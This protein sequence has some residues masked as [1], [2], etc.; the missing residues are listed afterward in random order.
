MGLTMIIPLLSASTWYNKTADMSLSTEIF[1]NAALNNPNKVEGYEI[2][3]TF[4]NLTQSVSNPSVFYSVNFSLA[5][6]EM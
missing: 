5:K 4:L 2:L 3:A 1:I 6:G